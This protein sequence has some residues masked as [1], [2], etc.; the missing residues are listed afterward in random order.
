[1]PPIFFWNDYTQIYRSHDVIPLKEMTLEEKLNAIG[2]LIVLVTI[3]TFCFTLDMNA[4]IGGM[5]AI[6]ILIFIYHM[7]KGIKEPL[8]FEDE[9]VVSE[10]KEVADPCLKTNL[11]KNFNEVTDINPLGNV[12]MTEFKDNPNRKAAPPS[13][14][15]EVNQQ[16]NNRTKQM[17]QNLN[18]TI[19]DVDKQLFGDIG[20]MFELEQSQ[21]NFY[22]T[23][24]TR[25]PNN[26]TAFANWCYGT[27]IS[28]KEQNPA[29]LMKNNPRYT[30]Y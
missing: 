29:A 16:I 11:A 17:V 26:Q 8:S 24:N 27:M 2:R 12:L 9:D 4:V 10:T 28:A 13:F 5:L 6:A 22:S 3:V 23:A 21:R 7:K 19:E 14:N 15:I 18:P 20:E 30:L 1:M 25:I